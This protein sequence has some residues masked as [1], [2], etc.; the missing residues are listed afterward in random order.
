VALVL[1]DKGQLVQGEFTRLYPHTRSVT[2]RKNHGD[3]FARQHGYVA[4]QN[5]DVGQPSLGG[6]RKGLNR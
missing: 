5:A 4:G 2:D 1:R 6:N 3:A